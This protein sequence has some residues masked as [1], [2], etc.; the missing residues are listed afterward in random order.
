M[1]ELSIDIPAWV[2]AVKGGTAFFETWSKATGELV[3]FA[4]SP[5]RAGITHDSQMF[6]NLVDGSTYNVYELAEQFD[7]V[8]KFTLIAGASKEAL[9]APYDSELTERSEHNLS[10]AYIRARSGTEADEAKLTEAQQAAEFTT[11]AVEV[12]ME[13]RRTRHS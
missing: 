1:N 5:Y 4:R 8:R 7:Q 10:V 9:T 11:H 2:P 6:I 12:A 3:M 13:K